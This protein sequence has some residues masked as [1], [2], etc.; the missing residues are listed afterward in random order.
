M[1]F[2]QTSLIFLIAFILTACSDNRGQKTPN[3][4]DK[5][6]DSLSNKSSFYIQ[7]QK[8]I[9][10][11]NDFEI[12]VGQ[13]E[14]FEKFETYT[15]FILAHKSKQLYIDTSLTEYEFGNNLYPIV[16][17]LDK[18][19]F[20]IFVE[21]ND[22]PNKNHLKYFK[23][24]QDKIISR[25]KLPSF[26]SAA[27]NLDTDNNLEL[28]GFLD[29]GQSWGNNESI[30][31]YNPIIYYELKPEG[32]TLDST[33][34]ISKN[35]DVYGDFYGFE[36]NEKLEIKTSVSKKWNDEIDRIIRRK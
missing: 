35:K 24:H 19:T 10:L 1:K 9:N 28:A 13:K 12:K 32:I 17:Q 3:E 21:V 14:E 18:E 25:Q 8:T 20:E 5:L 26:I 7:I 27:S 34:T 15:L 29:W 4:A 36:Y 2:D 33:L 22:R 23:V 11:D 31:A 16:R 30:T 6:S